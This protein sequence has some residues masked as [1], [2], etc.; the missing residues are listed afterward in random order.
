MSYATSLLMAYPP[1]YGPSTLLSDDLVQRS[2]RGPFYESSVPYTSSNRLYSDSLTY[3]PIGLG[4]TS[5][6]PSAYSQYPSQ[7]I[8]LHQ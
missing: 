7:T 1:P 3:N 2:S 5:Y 4:S 8:E 6:Q